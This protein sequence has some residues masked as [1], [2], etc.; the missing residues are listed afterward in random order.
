M[1]N[2]M[3]SQMEKD[4]FLETETNADPFVSLFDST[5]ETRFEPK[6]EQTTAFSSPFI[7]ELAQFVKNSL[8]SIK[9]IAQLSRGKFTDVKFEEHFNRLLNDN[10]GKIDSVLEGFLNYIKINTPVRKANTVHRI[11]EEVLKKYEA[12]LEEKKVKVLKKYEKDLP[13]TVVHDEQLRYILHSLL[14]YTI[15][16]VSPNGSI[17]WIT[18][19]FQIQKGLVVDEA[20]PEK[21]GRY[22]EIMVVFSEYKSPIED[23]ENLSGIS[24]SQIKDTRD[25]VLRLVKEM[26]QKNK[27]RIRIEV[28]EKKPRTFISLIFPVERRS[29]VYYP[30]INA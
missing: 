18:K 2:S 10:L 11:L 4:L 25:L 9:S 26:I 5:E 24:A 7:I 21:D 13:E 20:A 15:S 19:S 3:R 22:V 12:Q 16:S 6:Q 8:G 28:D 1:E 29:S 30:S 23:V 14:R 17:I 27:G